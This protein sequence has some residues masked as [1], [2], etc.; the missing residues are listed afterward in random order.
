MTD[1]KLMKGLGSGI[2]AIGGGIGA[3]G[4]GIGG[5]AGFGQEAQEE[6]RTGENSP[7][8]LKRIFMEKYS[9]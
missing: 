4:K 8:D 5:L 3:I 9:I 1:N 6:D 7:A 2:G